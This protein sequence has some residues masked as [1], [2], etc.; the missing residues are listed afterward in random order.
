MDK[1]PDDSFSFVFVRQVY[2]YCAD[3]CRRQARIDDVELAYNIN[4]LAHITNPRHWVL[5][6]PN[7]SE[8]EE[9]TNMLAFVIAPCFREKANDLWEQI[10]KIATL[11]AIYTMPGFKAINENGYMIEE[12]N[13]SSSIPPPP[14][15][16]VPA[17]CTPLKASQVV[18]TNDA[19]DTPPIIAV[20]RVH[21]PDFGDDDDE[22]EEKEPSIPE[23]STTTAPDYEHDELA[24]DDDK[25][26]EQNEDEQD[27]ANKPPAA[28]KHKFIVWVQKSE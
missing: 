20:K 22:E 8:M 3:W 28:K 4:L 10:D 26:D 25:D 12:N 5:R 14:P 13:N 11:Y 23:K 15:E 17:E 21:S 1:I 7:P 16:L 9:I 19:V 6:G 18:G 24:D 27:T 2:G